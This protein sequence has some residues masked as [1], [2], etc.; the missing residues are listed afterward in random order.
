[1]A[2][3]IAIECLEEHPNAAEIAGVIA[4]LP[5]I[6]D[7][8]LPRLADRWCNTI[9]IADA[10]AR[11][12]DVDAPLVLEV[13]ATFD[14]VQGLWADELAGSTDLDVSV[15]CAAM[16][17]VR[18][19]IAGAYAKPILS[20]SAYASLLRP[21]RAVYPVDE[22]SES[23]LGRRGVEVKGLLSGLAWLGTR[24]HDC[25]AAERYDQLVNA[26]WVSDGEL[27][28]TAREEALA[29]ATMTG[30]KRSWGL[31]RRSGA[32]SMSRGCQQCGPRPVDADLARVMAMCLDAACGL[33][34]ADA[35]SDELLDALTGPVRE[36]IPCPRSA[37]D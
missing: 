35:L 21:W 3:R 34:V 37:A 2:R 25:T 31:L 24:C 10:R 28:K 13:L 23:D 19:A 4:R 26:A 27:R 6:A 11:A 8:D 5:H 30:R 12:L 15:V 22:R 36:L 1:M 29:A 20:R 14:V 16:K 33:L 18:D 7:H 17:A 9:A 32:D